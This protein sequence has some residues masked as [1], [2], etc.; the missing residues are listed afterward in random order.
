MRRRNCSYTSPC[1]ARRRSTGSVRRGK[2]VKE[3]FGHLVVADAALED[4]IRHR[5][6][7]TGSLCQSRIAQGVASE[8]TRIVMHRGQRKNFH[9]RPS[10]AGAPPRS[11]NPRLG[12]TAKGAR[13]C[14]AKV[15]RAAM[16]PAAE[17]ERAATAEEIA[18]S[19]RAPRR[20]ILHE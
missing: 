14:T 3:S 5:I 16:A 9:D 20:S 13:D 19:E 7:W 18:Q 8:I 15:L 17:P 10:A 11:A 6:T 1:A 2:G 4:D 12:C